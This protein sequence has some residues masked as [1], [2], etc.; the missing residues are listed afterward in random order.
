MGWLLSDWRT[1]LPKRTLTNGVGGH[2]RLHRHHELLHSRRP[3]RTLPRIEEM[4][5]N[6]ILPIF[7]RLLQVTM[8]NAKAVLAA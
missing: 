3:L 7:H 1:D 8:N 4:E 2:L 6:L 5:E